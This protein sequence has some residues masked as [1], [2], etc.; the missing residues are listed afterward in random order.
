[1]LPPDRQPLIKRH[2]HFLHIIQ[3]APPDL[4]LVGIV[5]KI[6]GLAF[7]IAVVML[8]VGDYLG[9]RKQGLCSIV[10]GGRLFPR[11]I[12]LNDII[13]NLNCTL[14]NILFQKETPQNT[15][16]HCMKCFEGL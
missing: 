12:I 14:L 8:A 11:S 10:A 13:G 1:M 16:L 5:H 4:D 15:F 2:I 6:F 3:T 9:E 7:L